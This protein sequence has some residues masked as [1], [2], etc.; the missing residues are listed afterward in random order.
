MLD[1]AKNL[2]VKEISLAKKT[3]EQSVEAELTS[4]FEE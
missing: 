4:I 3:D 2:L 1:T